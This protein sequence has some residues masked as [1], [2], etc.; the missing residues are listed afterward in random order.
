M[1]TTDILK[2]RF[3]CFCNIKWDIHSSASCASHDYYLSQHVSVYIWKNRHA[4]LVPF[5][6]RNLVNSYCFEPYSKQSFEIW[7]KQT[8]DEREGVHL[9]L[10]VFT[11][12]I[13]TLLL[14]ATGVLSER[15]QVQKDTFTAISG[16]V[17]WGDGFLVPML[18]ARFQ[19]TRL[20]FK[21]RKNS[22]FE[23]L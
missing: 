20:F 1:N 12:I 3:V 19:G 5:Q 21:K 7:F 4:V 23:Q 14:I 17:F 6:F 16:V 10:F 9:A 22:M 8:T 2:F 15:Y 13:Q 11:N 18:F